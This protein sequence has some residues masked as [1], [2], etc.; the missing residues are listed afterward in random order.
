[1]R[2]WEFDSMAQ[3]AICINS[4]FS[5]THD[6]RSTLIEYLDPTIGK[7]LFKWSVFVKENNLY[8]YTIYLLEPKHCSDLLVIEK[9]LHIRTQKLH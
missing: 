7:L 1:M 9:L 8:L 2:R 4:W 6:E 5:G 3:A